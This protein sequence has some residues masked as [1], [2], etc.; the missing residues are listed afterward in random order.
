MTK[1]NI[2]DFYGRILGTIETEKN[3]NKIARDFYGRYLGKYD[4]QLNRTEDF[5]GKIL[6][7]GDTLSSLII[8]NANKNK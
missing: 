6:S 4:K 1:E 5:Y 8:N 2:T 7:S 3:G